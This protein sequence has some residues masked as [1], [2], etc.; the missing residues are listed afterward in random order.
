V[1]SSYLPGETVEIE[2]SYRN[3]NAE[4]IVVIPFPPQIQITLPVSGE[5][6]CSFAAGTGELKLVPGEVS[7]HTLTWDQRDD[8]GKQATPGW[9][10]VDARDIIIT[11]ADRKSRLDIG[12]VTKVL[13]QY[14]QGTMKKDIDV[15]RSRT[16][17][18]I[19]IILQRMEMLEAE[20]RFYAFTIPP[21]YTPP[22]PLAPSVPVPPDMVPVH[23]EYAA[24]GIIKDGGYASYGTR[25]DGVRLSWRR[26]DPVPSDAK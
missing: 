13:I 9:Y 10:S 22:S 16:V 26:L 11:Q 19:T 7:I 2:F 15:N 25:D 4:P 20:A 5:V 8:G 14:P 1:Q 21:G 3:P 12:S 6:V 18:G 17:S 24:D 23:A